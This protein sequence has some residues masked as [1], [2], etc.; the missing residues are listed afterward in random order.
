[1]V[2]NVKAVIAPAV[3][4]INRCNGT[5]GTGVGSQQETREAM[6]G[7]VDEAGLCRLIGREIEVA[8][9]RLIPD[10][11]IVEAILRAELDVMLA[12]DIGHVNLADGGAVIR[13]AAITGAEPP[14]GANATALVRLSCEIEYREMGARDV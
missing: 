11:V 5:A 1:I 2:L 12:P 13:A 6:A 8:R 14:A 10:V 3:S 9:T 4:K 7:L